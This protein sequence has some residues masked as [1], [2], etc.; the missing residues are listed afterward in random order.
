[1]GNG[2]L[3]DQVGDM[4]KR[5][6]GLDRLAVRVRVHELH[7]PAKDNECAAKEAEQHPVQMAC[8]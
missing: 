4:A 1:M 7:D 6:I 3:N 5:T 8:S 2:W